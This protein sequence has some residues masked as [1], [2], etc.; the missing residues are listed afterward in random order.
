MINTIIS[1]ITS[2]L[3]SVLYFLTGLYLA[4]TATAFV[5]A[6]HFQYLYYNMSTDHELETVLKHPD[7]MTVCQ[8]VRIPEIYRPE[9]SPES[10]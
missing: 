10:G 2:I 3:L 1:A 5:S 9:K 8:G 7:I 4:M 6:G